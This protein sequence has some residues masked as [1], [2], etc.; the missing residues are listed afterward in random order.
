[1]LFQ[2]NNQ[3]WESFVYVPKKPI[4][5]NQDGSY[6]R[7]VVAELV[8]KA[9]AGDEQATMQLFEQY[10]Y[11]WRGALKGF[12]TET[13][14]YEDIVQ[15]LFVVFM[16]ALRSFHNDNSEVFTSYY[17]SALKR[18]L[19]RKTI[20]EYIRNKEALFSLDELY[21]DGALKHDIPDKEYMDNEVMIYPRVRR[22][23][24]FMEFRIIIAHYVLEL[25]LSDIA[26]VVG[27]SLPSVKRLSAKAKEKLRTLVE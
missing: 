4:G 10:Q 13:L 27:Y 24:N 6:D 16:E 23:L 17:E 26:K 12:A 19:K 2:E 14:E 1:M 15:D 7:K 18:V 25:K 3:V 5:R 22:I 20:E 8:V 11:L 21:D 9:K